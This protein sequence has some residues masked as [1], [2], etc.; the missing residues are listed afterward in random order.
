MR[1][2]NTLRLPRCD[3]PTAPRWGCRAVVAR[4]PLFVA[5]LLMVTEWQSRKNMAIYI[6]TLHQKKRSLL[7]G[8][9][10]FIHFKKFP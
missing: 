1:T 10:H 3:S 4:Q 9:Q 6:F 8:K 2:A 5:A 7:L